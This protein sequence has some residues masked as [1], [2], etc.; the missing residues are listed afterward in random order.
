MKEEIKYADTYLTEENINM[1]KAI[2]S[3]EEQYRY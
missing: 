3:D 1:Q 2:F